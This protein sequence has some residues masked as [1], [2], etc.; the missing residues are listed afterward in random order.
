MTLRHRLKA[1]VEKIVPHVLFLLYSM[2]AAIIYAHHRPF[3]AAGA[4]PLYDHI[5]SHAPGWMGAVAACHYLAPAL[6]TYLVAWRLPAALGRL[7]SWRTL[8][9]VFLRPLAL[10]NISTPH[11]ILLFCGL[12]AATIHYR[13]RPF[14][15]PGSNPVLDL[16][17]FHDPVFHGVIW[18]WHHLAPLFAVLLA[19]LFL[20][21]IYR[22]W[23]E[24]D[25][26]R[27]E[28]GDL[29][30]WPLDPKD[31]APSLVIGELHHPV[32]A[33]ESDHPAWLTIP[34]RGLFTGLAI[35]GAVGSGKTSACMYPFARQLFT[36]QADNPQ[37]RAAGLVLEV[38]GDFCHSVRRILADAKRES[39]YMEIGLEGRWQWNPL[40][41]PWLDSYSLA[42]TVSSLLNQLFGKGKEPFW[43]QAYTNLVR[44]IIELHRALPGKWVTFKDVY[45]CT[46][47]PQLLAQKIDQAELRAFLKGEGKIV[48][49]GTDLHHD[50]QWP[51]LKAWP[52]VR[53][54]SD[55]QWAAPFDDRLKNTLN[56]LGID[57]TLK[58][59]EN[60]ATS[61]YHRRIVAIK[62]WYENDWMTLDIKLRSSIVEG[63][64]VFLSMFDLPE[65]ASIFC[66]DPPPPPDPD[67]PPPGNSL[68]RSH[69]PLLSDLIEDGKVLCLNMPAGTNP[70]LARS[71]GVM[72]KNAWLQAMLRRPAQMEQDPDR[73]FRPA[74]FLCDEYQSFASVGEDDPSGDEKS[75]A[76]TRQCRCIPIVATQSIS[77]LR[78]AIHGGEAWRTLLQT[79]R[80]KL[81]LS[82]S[83]DA[84]ARIASE[85]CGSVLKMRPSYSFTENTGRAGISLLSA[86]PGGSQGSMGTSKSFRESREPIFHPR[87]F[88]LLGNCQAI[89]LPYDGVQSL[90]PSRVYLKPH[91][92]NRD[93][94]YWRL[95]EDR[96]L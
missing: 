30:P 60:S 47:N 31:P 23:I 82:L 56:D 96:K 67:A 52:W 81:F 37:Q 93:T 66:P 90:S 54:N 71:I 21:S 48:V 44:W 8:S 33:K 42:Y 22:V 73:Y 40:D 28:K 89:C 20:L 64:S 57:F 17:H 14:P 4:N 84:S 43:Q 50:D 1:A 45:H 16:L 19:G 65:I 61:D 26:L 74:L 13:Y 91:Y 2:G 18:F 39:D 95:K 55:A 49:D 80:T 70:A 69:L 11:A 51:T 94:S 9:H 79:L 36:W 34:E 68:S 88:S 6:A 76:L 32:E 92:L 58:W 83:D 86:R 53:L 72:L 38:K 27:A 35:F 25:G 78:S 62:T 5:R 63:I 12:T 59:N 77:S 41:A 75:F 7:P 24:G 85:L 15:E 3:P 29:P 46:I 10:I 87:D